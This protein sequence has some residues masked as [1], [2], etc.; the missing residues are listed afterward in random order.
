MTEDNANI[1]GKWI[2]IG[3]VEPYGTCRICDDEMVSEQ[4]YRHHLK[5]VHGLEP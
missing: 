3:Q 1:P 5:E 2:E 4:D